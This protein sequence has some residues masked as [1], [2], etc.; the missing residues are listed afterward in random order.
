M[1]IPP[2]S[3][4]WAEVISF[5]TQNRETPSPC[6]ARHLFPVQPGR[7][8]T[9]LP[10]HFS[11]CFSLRNRSAHQDAHQAVRRLFPRATGGRM[12]RRQ[13]SSPPVPPSTLTNVL[14][15]RGRG[16]GRGRFSKIVPFPSPI[17]IYRNRVLAQTKNY[18]RLNT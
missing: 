4:P 6:N 5:L 16:L 3:S 11:K 2:N 14:R 10:L 1:T 15:G 17:F 12:P 7:T 9:R 13:P 8:T 18:T